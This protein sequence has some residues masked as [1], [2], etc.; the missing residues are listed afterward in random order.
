MKTVLYTV[1]LALIISI[2]AMLGFFAGNYATVQR[3]TSIIDYVEQSETLAGVLRSGG[4]SA[5]QQD[6]YLQAYTDSAAVEQHTHTISWAVKNVPTPFVGSAP[7][8]GTQ[9]NATINTWQMRAGHEL[10]SPKPARTFRVFLTGG[11]TAYGSGAPAQ[12][13]TIG[14]YLAQLMNARLAPATG[15][16]YEVFTFANPAWAST[17][18]RIAIE[19][20]LSE[21]EP[22]LIVSLSGNN[23][24]F[25]GD[26]GRNV[27]WFYTLTEEYFNLLISAALEMSGRPVLPALSA[28]SVVEGAQVPPETVAQRL[29]KNIH[30]GAYAMSLVKKPWVFFLQPT[31]AVSGKPLTAREQSF[32]NDSKTYYQACY[33]AMQQHLNKIDIDNFSYISLADVFDTLA[34]DEDIFLDSFHF[35]DKGNAIIAKAMFNELYSHL[36]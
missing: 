8:P 36:Q 19:N 18:E 30:L 29:V 10:I 6:H 31:L 25:W 5:L 23:D 3:F 11:S 32:L 28:L 15:L 4:L 7:W 2:P 1:I 26:A 22:D 21:L 9:F 16:H 35:G 13:R 24:V 20:Y 14:A 27:L 34:H 17:H 12:A 33:R